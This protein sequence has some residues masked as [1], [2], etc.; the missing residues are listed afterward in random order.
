MSVCVCV[1]V[2]SC[3]CSCVSTVKPPNKGHIGTR[4][5]VLLREVVHFLEVTNVL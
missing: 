3:V 5:F 2:C 4:F 1:R